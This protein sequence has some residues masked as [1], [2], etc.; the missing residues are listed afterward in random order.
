MK[1]E[2]DITQ[3]LNCS[4]KPAYNVKPNFWSVVRNLGLRSCISQHCYH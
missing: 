3:E 2:L 1:K 4:D